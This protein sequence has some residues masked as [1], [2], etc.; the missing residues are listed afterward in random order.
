MPDRQGNTE[1]SEDAIPKTALH[2]YKDGRKDDISGNADAL[3]SNDPK[4]QQ[5]RALEGDDELD[6][7][8]G[9]R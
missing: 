4:D 7:P 1:A 6:L 5:Q 8:H 2:A 9:K 3:E